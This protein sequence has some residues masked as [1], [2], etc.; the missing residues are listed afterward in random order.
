MTA[1]ARRSLSALHVAATL[2]LVLINGL[3]ADAFAVRRFSQQ[4][5]AGSR[6]G[7]FHPRRVGTPVGVGVGPGTKRWSG[8]DDD[9]ALADAR[10]ICAASSASRASASAYADTDAGTDAGTGTDTAS[11]PPTAPSSNAL[12]VELVDEDV[13]V[14]Q[15]PRTLIDSLNLEL[16][17]GQRLAI[18]GSN[19][20]GKSILGQL[21]TR[22]LMEAT[23][24]TSDFWKA[25]ELTPSSAMGSQ[26]VGIDTD[27]SERTVTTISF[28]S[29]R[30][31][32]E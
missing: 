6:A 22:R 29:H 14:G 12:L 21:L 19:G 24:P 23:T 3:S 7:T 16:R 17:S 4:R 27:A 31:V 28:E 15:P 10:A 26:N 9:A 30:R 13:A 8:S 2:L 1:H 20:C 11:S 5:R 18:L 32:S 25:R